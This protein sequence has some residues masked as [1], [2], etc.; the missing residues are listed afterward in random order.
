MVTMVSS[1]IDEDSSGLLKFFQMYSCHKMPLIFYLKLKD[2]IFGK[3]GEKNCF[4]Y[5]EF[6]LSI[7]SGLQQ[8]DKEEMFQSPCKVCTALLTFISDSHIPS[9]QEKSVAIT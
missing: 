2:F 4:V 9:K 7:C 3:L 8:W 1:N 6:S 5:V